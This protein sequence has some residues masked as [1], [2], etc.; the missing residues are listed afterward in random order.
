MTSGP[1]K[2]RVSDLIQEEVARLLQTSMHDARLKFVTV[3]AV[4]MTSDLRHARIHVSTL[5][6]GEAREETMRALESARGFIRKRLAG[7]LQLRFT[8][9]IV[10]E[11]DTSIERGARI[12]K[13]LEEIH[14]PEDDPGHGPD[15]E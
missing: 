3:T 9:D 7:T 14:P 8:P 12:E 2:E 1:R 4:S 13:L 10:F 5:A 6:E 11:F 15:K